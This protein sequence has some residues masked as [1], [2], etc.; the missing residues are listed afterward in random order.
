MPTDFLSAPAGQRRSPARILRRSL[1]RQVCLER[2]ITEL[3]SG[4]PRQDLIYG[5]A[6]LT[7]QQ[8]GPEQLL[9]LN[10]EHWGIEN[11][12]HWVGDVTFGEDLS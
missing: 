2:E 8:A 9:K 6:G 10:R 12:S 4:K 7:P 11:G 3:R 5:L 1:W